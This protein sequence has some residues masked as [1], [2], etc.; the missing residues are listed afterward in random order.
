MEDRVFVRLINI[1][2]I[3]LYTTINELQMDVKQ[4]QAINQSLSVVDE[5]YISV[6]QQPNYLCNADLIL[7]T[8][9]QKIAEIQ[10]RCCY[11]QLVKQ[12]ML[13]LVY[14]YWNKKKIQ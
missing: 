10:L 1:V 13:L 12:F 11:Y 5:N 6:C 4:I 2:I 8:D 9:A 3:R 7:S 14:I